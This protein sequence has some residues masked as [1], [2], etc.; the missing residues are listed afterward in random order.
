MSM[1]LVIG[2]LTRKRSKVLY[3]EKKVFTL[4]GMVF[5]VTWCGHIRTGMET[6]TG[7]AAN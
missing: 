3:W 7:R 1:D 2:R 6:G 5:S 4:L